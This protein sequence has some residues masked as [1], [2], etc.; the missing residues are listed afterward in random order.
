MPKICT[1]F[2]LVYIKKR[3]YFLLTSCEFG[4]VFFSA[5]FF[6]LFVNSLCY[7]TS[8]TEMTASV[9]GNKSK[10]TRGLNMNAF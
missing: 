7:K 3:S 1:L 10:Y 2:G 5:G 6:D 4:F 9:Q 8:K